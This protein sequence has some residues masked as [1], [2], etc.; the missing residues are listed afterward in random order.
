[1]GANVFSPLY[2][3]HAKLIKQNE[4][5]RTLI[6]N[7]YDRACER[8]L[9]SFVDLFENLLTSTF[10][11]P[12]V[13]LKCATVEGDEGEEEALED[14]VLPSFEDTKDRI[15]KEISGR[16]GVETIINKWLADIPEDPS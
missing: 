1:M 16:S 13:F 5:M 9:T 2:P 6:F 3:K 10:S 8:H 12:W 4:M 7:T 11:N 15:P 14:M